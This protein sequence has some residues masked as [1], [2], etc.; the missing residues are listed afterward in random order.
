MIKNTRYQN[1]KNNIKPGI[2]NWLTKTNSY[3][4]A[5]EKR[6]VFS[7][8]LNPDKEDDNPTVWGNDVHSLGAKTE[9]ARS[10][11]DFRRDNGTV[12]KI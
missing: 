3:E 1:E 5:W 9:T 8:D 11:L 4:L 7:D 10:P 12:K 6:Y 2:R